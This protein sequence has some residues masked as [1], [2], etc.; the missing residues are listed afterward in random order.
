MASFFRTGIEENSIEISSERSSFG[1][2]AGETVRHEF[3][4]E[5]V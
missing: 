5:A 1:T 2:T 4:A 3:I